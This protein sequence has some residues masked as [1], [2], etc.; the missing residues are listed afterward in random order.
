MPE[1]GSA[2][3]RRLGPWPP[4]VFYR[5]SIILRHAKT[6]GAIREF[7]GRKSEQPAPARSSAGGAECTFSLPQREFGF[8]HRGAKRRPRGMASA[9]VC[10]MVDVWEKLMYAVSYISENGM[11]QQLYGRHTS[12]YISFFRCIAVWFDV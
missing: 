7:L 4:S 9:D 5:R 2:E 6:D 11:R 8:E 1:A 12:A 10:C 3:A